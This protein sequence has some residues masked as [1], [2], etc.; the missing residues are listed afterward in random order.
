VLLFRL[1]TVLGL[2]GPLPVGAPAPPPPH[3]VVKDGRTQPVFSYQ[4]VIRETVYVDVPT[5]SDN[6]GRNDRVAV[7]ITRPKA[8]DAG[9]KVASI[10]EASPYFGGTLDTPY[11]PVDVTDR[12]RLAP[13]TP[14]RR[15]WKTPDYGHVY[16]D[17]YFV[18]RGYA[19]LAVSTLGT[20]DSTGCPGAVSPDEATAMKTVVQW[21]TGAASAHRPDGTPAPATWST[22]SVAMAGKSYDGTLPLATAAT[23]VDG[24]KTIVSISGVA[25]W[26]DYY[27]GN[28]GVIAPGGYP[29][30]DADLHAKVVLTRKNPEVCTPAIHAMEQAMDRTTG[31]ENAFWQQRDFAR[32]AGRFKASVFVT[33]GLH[34]WNVKPNQFLGLWQALTRAGVPR[35]LWIHQAR[36][37]DPIDLRGPQW[38]DTLNRWFAHWLYG[39]A[40]GIMT[41]PKVDLE[42]EPGQWTTENDWPD[43]QARTVTLN[44]GPTRLGGPGTSA[45]SFQDAPS[46]TAEQLTAAP[47][48]QDPGRLIYLT[49]PLTGPQRLSGTPRIRLNASL[50]GPGPYLSAMLVDYGAD[51]RFAGLVPAGWRWCFG[52]SGPGDPGCRPARR[53]VTR[54]TPYEIVTRG[55]IDVRNR[56]T[57]WRTDPIT[58]GRTYAFEW[59]L[60][61]YDHVFKPGHRIALVIMGTDREYTLR[62]PAGTTVTVTGGGLSLPLAAR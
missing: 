17:N 24:L 54:T 44:L 45:Q 12:P 10:I 27:R 28:G 32:Q 47:D 23:G 19:V 37:D 53:Y 43:P 56:T 49:P 21:L 46:R 5:D 11:H 55:W 25:D 38:L 35:K 31:D 16:Y 52:D 15:P 42:R 57:P 6:D 36:H 59:P 14:P 61:P 40:N 4:D 34:D 22:G 2:L 62:Y 29:G 50:R 60:V 13:W 48:R 9:L 51:T 20:G 30:E 41:E 18:P 33:G 39:A 26:Y 7:H 58:P 8:T 3:V 1:V